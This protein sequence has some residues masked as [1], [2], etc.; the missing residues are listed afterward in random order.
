MY[1]R[2]GIKEG[3]TVRS[4]DGHRL[5][6][7]YAVG[8]SEFHIEKGLFFPKDYSVR[9][10]EVGDIVDGEIILAHGKDSLR[11]F[12]TSEIHDIDP[13]DSGRVGSAPASS[14]AVERDMARSDPDAY[15]ALPMS[16]RIEGLRTEDL[17]NQGIGARNTEGAQASPFLTEEDRA[18]D[19]A[20]ERP[21]PKVLPQEPGIGLPLRHEGTRPEMRAS[22]PEQEPTVIV[23]DELYEETRR[24]NMRGDADPN[25]GRRLNLSGE[26]DPKKRGY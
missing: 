19:R 7:V 20:V 3:M 11:P 26:Q 25:S 24:L 4:V 6:R 9:Y 21:A 13:L 2:E 18:R 17:G 10:S 1:Q 22:T 14:A 23:E 5:G 15:A 16:R 12:S 8:E